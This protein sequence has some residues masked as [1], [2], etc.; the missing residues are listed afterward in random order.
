MHAATKHM[1]PTVMTLHDY[2]AVCP[3]GGLFLY[4]EKQLC[5]LRPMS[6][7]CIATQC[8][9]RSYSHKLWRVAR[10]WLQQ[11][12]GGV[13]SEIT[14]FISISDTSERL[15]RPYLPSNA[16][17]Q[18]V[19]N[20]IQIAQEPP[21]D[22]AQN[23]RFCF[24]GRLSPEKGPAL[25]AQQRGMKMVFVGDGPERALL[26]ATAPDAEFTGWVIGEKVREVMRSSRAL[27]FPSLWYET[28]GLTV[29]EAAAIGLPAVVPS[30]SAAREWVE[31]GVTGMV[32][33][34]AN[35]NDLGEKLRW[36][37]NNPRQAARMGC[38]AYDRY[39]ER[40]CT[41]NTH[42]DGLEGI[43]RD[44]LRQHAESNV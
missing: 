13:P 14:R 22:A 40:P 24:V 4:P 7:A 39:W 19:S 34:H 5:H 10:Q 3:N 37:H 21:M 43:Y 1:F 6:T 32:F 25:L 26:E 44:A 11:N 16:Q 42:C 27:V 29:L 18:R 30:G 17:I 20:P 31:D 15:L 2:F 35:A 33:Q 28:Q 41:M 12:V 8:D 36:L 9:S 38:A 23:D